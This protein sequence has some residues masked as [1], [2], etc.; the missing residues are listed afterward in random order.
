MKKILLDKHGSSNSGNP[1]K[2]RLEHEISNAL[3][4]SG[5]P[6]AVD[7]ISTEK[8]NLGD[9]NQKMEVRLMNHPSNSKKSGWNKKPS[10]NNSPHSE[11][12]SVTITYQNKPMGVIEIVL[13]EQGMDIDNIRDAFEHIAM[14]IAFFIKRQQAHKRI[15]RTKQ[16]DLEWVGRSAGSKTVDRFIEKVS[17]VDFPVLIQGENG[18]GKLLTAYSIHCHSTRKDKPFIESH[19]PS[20]SKED[21]HSTMKK[22]W[23]DAQGG[24][25]YL[26]DFDALSQQQIA[27]IRN[28][29]RHVINVNHATKLQPSTSVR[30]IAS[31][32]NN[33]SRDDN[34]A[35]HELDYLSIQLPSLRDRRDDIKDLISHYLNKLSYIKN[36]QLSDEC[37]ELFEQF[38]WTG[39]LEQLER[40]VSKLVVM[41]DSN[42]LDT[43]ALLAIIPQLKNRQGEKIDLPQTPKP[44]PSQSNSLHQLVSTIVN[45][46][47]TCDPDQHPAVS[48]ALKHLAEHYTSE[49]TLGELATIACVSQSH[50]SYLFK[51]H[52][53]ASFKQLL[54]H[55]RIE[56]AKQL[57]RQKKYSKITEISFDVG[58]HDLSHFEKTFKRLVGQS[59]GRFRNA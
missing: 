41:S 38:H 43:S 17:S 5:A 21:I 24:T 32:S 19:C 26:Q 35:W 18:S 3:R 13:S 2:H 34:K 14:D 29:W 50:L 30:L 22:L 9:D 45:D 10:I 52:L 59:P 15:K 8:I 44:E 33:D 20:W 49:I 48:K 57:L 55:V 42:Y 11:S 37:W 56:K 54:I 12:V 4:D 58:F 46:N 53:D 36:V 47:Y 25:L 39:N 40:L 1:I 31:I 28:Y 51:Y 23:A 16:L 7:G 27:Q 6:Y